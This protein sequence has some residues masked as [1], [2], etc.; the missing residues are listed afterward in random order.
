MSTKQ[1]VDSMVG[2]HVTAR[3]ALAM[4]ARGQRVGTIESGAKGTVVGTKTTP[5]GDRIIRVQWD[6]DGYP[7]M[8]FKQDDYSR[9]L[10]EVEA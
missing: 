9:I 8:Q 1:D 10:A 2:Q 7:T 6:V 5:E 4:K 3:V